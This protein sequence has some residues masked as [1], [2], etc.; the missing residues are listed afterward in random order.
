MC[1]SRGAVNNR[2]PAF[3]FIIEVMNKK[4][5]VRR[6]P[7][8]VRRQDVVDAALEIIRRQ[9]VEKLTTRALSEAVGIAQPTLFLHFGNKA[10][11]LVAV[12][13]AIQARLQEGIK[14][15]ELERLGPLDR[16]KTTI[17]F[18]LKFIQKQP[19]IPR[20]L[21]SEELQQGDPEFRA[22]MNGMVGFFLQ[23][24]AKLIKDAQ[25]AGELR[26]DIDPE[27]YGCLLLGMIQGLAFRWILSNDR[28]VLQEQADA[29]ITT[30]IEGWAPT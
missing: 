23:F 13:D 25:E 18:H 2:V 1:R 22:R 4:V 29:V 28:F 10:R 20:L 7:A 17:R 19:G 8:E 30:I 27:Q 15:L 26:Q 16:L 3:S 6:K 11:M 14:G 9:G 5:K 12:V 24:L 21:F